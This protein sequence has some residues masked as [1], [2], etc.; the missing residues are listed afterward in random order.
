MNIVSPD[1]T[2]IGQGQGQPTMNIDPTALDDVTCDECENYTFLQVILMKR[3]PALIS[4]TGKDAFL[5]QSTFACA[6][7]NH[8]NV[9]F[10]QGMGGWFKDS[11]NTEGS[12]L[13]ELDDKSVEGSA[14]PG[15]ENVNLSGDD[16]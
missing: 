15:L 5:P 6:V 3:M 12:R 8:V 16:E 11:E 14:L 4:P 7:C 2:P 10:I 1:G 13:R 9:H